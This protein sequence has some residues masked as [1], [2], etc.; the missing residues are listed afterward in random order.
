MYNKTVIEFGFCDVPNYQLDIT[1]T[2][3]N[4]C[5][6]FRIGRGPE[7]K[8]KKVNKVYNKSNKFITRK[9]KQKVA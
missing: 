7:T 5:L 9:I 6:I 3:S 2:S 4:N 8:L 1:K